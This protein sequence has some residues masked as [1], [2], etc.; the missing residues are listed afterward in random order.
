MNAYTRTAGNDDARFYTAYAYANDINLPVMNLQEDLIS[1]NDAQDNVNCYIANAGTYPYD[2]VYNDSYFYPNSYTGAA[3]AFKGGRF[4]N[5]V[6]VNVT[7]GTLKVGIR[8]DG[9]GFDG[10]WL[11][12]GNINLIYH[13]ELAASNDALDRTLEDY[14]A[15]ANTLLEAEVS[16]TMSSNATPNFY[17]GYRTALQELIN[18]AE[19]ASSEADKYAAIQNFSS[20]FAQIKTCQLAYISVLSKI[21]AHQDEMTKKHDN[22]DITNEDYEAAM[23]EVGAAED[24]YWDGKYTTLE[25]QNLKWTVTAI[26]DIVADTEKAPVIYNLQGQKVQ[27]VT[28]GRIY[29]V[30]GKKVLVK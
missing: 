30:N 16:G 14:I 7:N 19:S 20:L 6:T 18:T 4:V 8:Q 11:V 28:K 1:F 2:V 17:A 15:R 3:F 5:N 29:I 22:G 25:A 10:D 9:S 12:C 21:D 23:A 13:G 24:A 27:N 26:D